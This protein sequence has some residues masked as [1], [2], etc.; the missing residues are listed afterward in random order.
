MKGLHGP[1][2]ELVSAPVDAARSL[3]RSLFKEPLREGKL[4]IEGLTG[5]VRTATI[6]GL[7]MIV[8]FLI[9]IL[10][11]GLWRRGELVPVGGFDAAFAPLPL[12]PVT[13]IALAISWVLLLSGAARA[14]ALPRALLVLAFL[15]VNVFLFDATQQALGRSSLALRWGPH[16]VKASYGL[17]AASALLQILGERVARFAKPT[18]VVGTFG[19]SLGVLSFFGSYLWIFYDN[20]RGPTALLPTQLDGAMSGVD[21]LLVPL[22]V[23][24]QLALVR[25][26]YDIAQG[27]SG[28]AWKMSLAAARYL[29]VALIVVKLAVQLV[30]LSDWAALVSDRPQMAAQTLAFIPFVAIAALIL[31]RIASD[32]SSA[33][34]A[35]E[36]VS[37]GSVIALSLPQLV[38][39]AIVTGLLFVVSLGAE[40]AIGTLRDLNEGTLVKLRDNGFVGIWVVM[41][42][43]GG[44]L[45]SKRSGPAREGGIALLLIAAWGL[46]IFVLGLLVNYEPHLSMPLLDMVITVIVGC[47]VAARFARLDVATAASLTAI[48]IFTWFLATEGDLFT[49]VGNFL[50]LPGTIVIV[51]GVV[52]TLLA[53]SGFATTASKRFPREARTLLWIGYL[54]LS[55]V[56]FNWLLAAHQSSLSENEVEQSLLVLGLP[57]AAWLVLRVPFSDPTMQRSPARSSACAGG[58]E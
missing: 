48:L 16:L 9:S 39:L 23:V 51:F 2:R 15:V 30:P 55:L 38:T 57:L 53:G 17:I 24:S 45:F 44:F 7:I 32:R 49:L 28:P 25:F 11:T 31:R 47:Y 46:P 40:S 29:L 13:L 18:K 41:A 8:F 3:Y 22:A 26:S 54:L 4:R 58:P 20:P 6:A 37:Y 34:E 19:M 42:A 52:F 1:L 12:V 35:E 43:V 50:K 33:G 27:V 36:A 14:S 21:I 10:L 5:L 56:I